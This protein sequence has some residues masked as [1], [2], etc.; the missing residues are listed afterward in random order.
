MVRTIYFSRRAAVLAVISVFAGLCGSSF[1][2][3]ETASIRGL[4]TDSSGALVA[5]AA[6]RLIDSDRGVASE[7]LTGNEGSY[8]LTGVR[9]GSYRMQVEKVG[10]RPFI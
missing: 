1:A 4:V 8:R 3:T 6:V 7:V 10:L 9:P 2:Q 5:N